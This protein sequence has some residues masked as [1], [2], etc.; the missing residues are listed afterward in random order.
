MLSFTRAIPRLRP[1]SCFVRHNSQS[2]IPDNFAQHPIFV[3]NVA[4]RFL[5]YSAYGLVFLGSTTA[6]MFE[7]THYWVEHVA[8]A[9]TEEGDEVRKWEWNL[10]G[11][12]WTTPAGGTDPGLGFK[13][14]HA[15]RAAWMASYWGEEHGPTVVTSDAVEHNPSLPGP[16]GIAVVDPRLVR[17]ELSLRAALDI[18]EQ[19]AIQGKLHPTTLP[20][21]LLLHASVLER[22]GPESSRKAKYQYERAWASHPPEVMSSARIATKL[23]DLNFRLGEDNS[24]L[25]WWNRA[26]HLTSQKSA[27]DNTSSPTFPVPDNMPLS[28]YD[29]RTLLSALTSVSA[30]YATT[31]KLKEARSVDERSLDLIRSVRQPDSLASASPPHALHALTL[32]QRSSVFSVHLA[33]VE[34]ALHRRIPSSLQWLSTAAQSSERT[35]RAL[36][37]LPIGISTKPGVDHIFTNKG[38]LPTYVQSVSMKKPAAS[39]LRDARRT[40]AESWNLMGILNEAKYPQTALECYERAVF[41]AGNAD[42]DGKPAEGTLQRDWDVIWGNYKRLKNQQ[43]RAV[44]R[45]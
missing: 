26:V 20:Q 11:E 15:V 25:A 1:R 4:K 43:Q 45:K 28:P 7:G 9:P 10:E 42:G 39:L 8:L 3:F 5:K 6:V 29:Q 19:K 37:G 40:V 30:F 17:T 2:S 21:L 12:R 35:A 13:G 24:A 22:M 16:G 36:T 34:Y 44:E 32:L 14:R 38:L 18:A 23:G 27:S 33:E 31:G 41:W